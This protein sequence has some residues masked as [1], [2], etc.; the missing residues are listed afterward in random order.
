MKILL[1]ED[2]GDYAEQFVKACAVGG[3]S[4]EFT[5]CTNR[6]DAVEAIQSKFFDYIVLDLSIPDKAGA[7]AT[8]DA[9]KSVIEHCMQERLGTPV[10]FLTAYASASLARHLLGKSS[11][12]DFWGSNTKQPLYQMTEKSSAN[13]MVAELQKYEALV[14]AV[15]AVE[16]EIEGDLQLAYDQKRLLK[17]FTRTRN[18][19]RLRVRSLSGGLS[20]VPV[21]RCIVQSNT[22]VATDLAVAKVGSVYDIEDDER[23]YHQYVK[24]LRE[25][26]FPVFSEALKYGSKYCCGIFYGLA[27]S[28]TRSA[29]DIAFDDPGK[30][31]TLIDALRQIYGRW[32][33]AGE[34]TLTVADIRRHSIVDAE[35]AK[36]E[37]KIGVVSDANLESF[38][39][40]TRECVRHGDLHGLNLLVDG[41][42]SPIL[43]DFGE[44]REA[45]AALDPVT[46]ELSTI[47]H[48]KARVRSQGWP[49][50]EQASKWSD[51][52]VF[53]E[54]SPCRDFVRACR[55]WTVADAAGQREILATAYGYLLRQL[56]YDRAEFPGDADLILAILNGVKAALRENCA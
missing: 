23:R 1:V 21:L 4:M 2:D 12:E 50:L 44:V 17:I 5:I 22:G 37:A 14:R 45:A 53:T 43:I 29:F 30:A 11:L 41:N 34:K 47:C 9:G 20:G 13:E 28:H 27:E 49:T 54:N 39:V 3:G 15:N 51:I 19:A 31:Q 7:V 38:P 36:L 48:P 52:D 10:G 24:R 26:A 35:L 16:L 32:A 8:T 55:N 56:K 46:L 18:G 25:G 33:S 42:A 6:E 40:Q